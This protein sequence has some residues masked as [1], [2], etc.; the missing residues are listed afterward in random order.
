MVERFC[1]WCRKHYTPKSSEGIPTGKIESIQGTAFDFTSA[2][3]VGK[4]INRVEGG[5]DHNYVLFGRGSDAKAATSSGV[6]SSQ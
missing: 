1:I 3:V 4:R 2:E 6:A 5:Y